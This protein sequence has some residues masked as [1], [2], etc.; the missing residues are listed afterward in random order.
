MHT[1]HSDRFIPLRVCVRARIGFVLT[2]LYNLLIIIY[3]IFCGVLGC[4]NVWWLLCVFNNS[5]VL[6]RIRLRNKFI[7]CAGIPLFDFAWKKIVSN[8]DQ[9]R[10]CAM[11]YTQ[12]HRVL[13]S[14][15]GSVF[16]IKA[17]GYRS[18]TTKSFM[19]PQLNHTYKFLSFS[20]FFPFLPFAIRIVVLQ[21]IITVVSKNI[22]MWSR[23]TKICRKSCRITSSFISILTI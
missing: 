8:I 22:I 10:M 2:Q 18:H 15:C 13:F 17:T 21:S 16:S 23:G 1:L 12:L 7:F 4:C 6:T 19:W 11:Y 14:V 3:F 5:Y 20:S 9:S